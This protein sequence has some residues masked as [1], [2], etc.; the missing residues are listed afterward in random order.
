MSYLSPTRISFRG[1]FLSDVS[2]RNNVEGNYRPGA[3]QENLWN[4]SGGASVE[5][6]DCGVVIAGAVQAGDP[7]ANFVVTG[8]LDRPSGKMVDLD[9]AWQMSSELWGMRLRVVDRTTGT[10]AV[11]GRMAVCAFR[12]LWTRQLDPQPNGQPAGARFVSSLDD[13]TWGSAAENSAAMQA[14]RAAAERGKLSLGWHTFGYFYPDTEARY[15]T[16]SVM[17]HIGPLK[18]GEPETA[19][20]HRRLTGFSVQPQGGGRPFAVTGD[21]DF[22]VTGGGTAACLDIGHALLLSDVDGRLLRLSSLPGALGRIRKLSIGLTPPG[23]PPLFS[24]TPPDQAIRLLD[25]PD[26]PEW[27]LRTGGVA[28]VAIPDTHAAAADSTRFALFA[29]RDDGQLLL[30]ATETEDGVFYRTDGFVLRLDTGDQSSVRFHARRFGR[31]LMGLQLHLAQVLPVNGAPA[32]DLTPPPP[33]DAAG[34][35]E[36]TLTGR[37]PGNPRSANALDGQIYAFGYSHKTDSDGQLD[38]KGTGLGG[39]DV[40]PVHVR[41]P[42][43]TP[44]APVFEDDVQPFMAQYAQLYPI[45]SQHL[46]D[47]ADYDALVA[48]RQA[49]LLAF[50]R[51]IA[52]PNYMPVTRDMSRGRVDTLVKWL[53]SETGDGAAPLRRRAGLTE[54]APTAGPPATQAAQEAPAAEVDV[55]TI[56]ATLEKRRT[57]L[58]IMPVSAL[59]D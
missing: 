51:D 37:D 9:P 15:R 56:M 34:V 26:D 45:M 4:A 6:L 1:R 18:A 46:F 10:L 53:S 7:A 17:L 25:I 58:P 21:I 30:V 31:P 29:E 3:P 40:I 28:E 59:E 57:H 39:L 5:L 36:A 38:L 14:L 55:K 27:Y 35:T 32:P 2:T 54:A 52:D 48:N 44:D 11:E 16:G 23:D 19:L 41:D 22:A 42:F 24:A 33:T 12:D 50:S 47:I 13:L 49:M 8:A 43:P 20:V